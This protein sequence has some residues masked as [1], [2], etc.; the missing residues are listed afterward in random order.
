MYFLG[1]FPMSQTQ[2]VTHVTCPIGMERP[3]LTWSVGQNV[4][5]QIEPRVRHTHSHSTR[6]LK[7]SGN[8]FDKW[9]LYST[10]NRVNTFVCI[11]NLSTLVKQ[12]NCPWRKTIRRRM[13]WMIF[14][15]KTS[16]TATVLISLDWPIWVAKQT[17]SMK[18]NAPFSAANESRLSVKQDH[19][20][21]LSEKMNLITNRYSWQDNSK[22]H[23]S[24]WHF[25]TKFRI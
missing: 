7:Y 20:I 9:A 25:C 1:V 5:I 12:D 23:L 17:K 8:H 14:V 6:V 16:P 10:N 18:T 24:F 11:Y 19:G 4:W 15:T 22:L 2:S 3:A 21:I 13:C